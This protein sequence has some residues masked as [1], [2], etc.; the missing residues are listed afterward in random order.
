MM[1]R[2]WLW[3]I[4]VWSEME[5]PWC[6]SRRT[7]HGIKSYEKPQ[8]YTCTNNECESYGGKEER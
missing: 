1:I 6:H 2:Y 4:G 3:K 7:K 8:Y 5:C